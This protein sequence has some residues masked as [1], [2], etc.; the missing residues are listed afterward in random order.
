MER[1]EVREFCVREGLALE[2]DKAITLAK[3]HFDVS[4]DPSVTLEQDPE[5]DHPHLVLEFKVKGSIKE[6]VA[7]HKAV[8]LARAKAV[9]WPNSDKIRI[10]YDI[11]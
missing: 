9:S 1:D 7:A 11:D 6:I 8:A 5:L 10:T 3:Q 4:S 2:L